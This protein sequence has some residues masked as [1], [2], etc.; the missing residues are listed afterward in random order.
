VT[1][2]GRHRV[3][4]Q[5]DLADIARIIEACPALRS[6]IPAEVLTRLV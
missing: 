3:K 4:R 1:A 5:K 2:G 6:T